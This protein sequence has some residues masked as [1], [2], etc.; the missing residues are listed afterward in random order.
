[1]EGEVYLTEQDLLR[2]ATYIRVT[3]GDFEDRYVHREKYLLRL[4][5]PSDRQCIFHKD[6]RCSIHAVKPTQCRVFPYW[7]EITESR[8]A[9]DE[10]A[11]Y[12]P[13]MNKG[14]LIQIEAAR[15]I[16]EEMHQGYPSMYGTTT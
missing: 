1:M 10:T 8:D 12:C 3:P 9:W 2:I 4:R 6:N 14:P 7:P 13:G 5:K 11:R 15:Q 16:G